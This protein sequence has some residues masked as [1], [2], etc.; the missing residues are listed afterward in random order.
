MTST[1]NNYFRILRNTII[2]C[3]HIHIIFVNFFRN[4]E[5]LK[6]LFCMN[7]TF[8]RN[9]EFTKMPKNNVSN[10]FMS[11]VSFAVFVGLL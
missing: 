4:L 8:T 6:T 1:K 2:S 9:K 10:H 11:F 7:V 5:Y 3:K